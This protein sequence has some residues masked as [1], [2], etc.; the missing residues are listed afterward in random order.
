MPTGERKQGN[1]GVG[2]VEKRFIGCEIQKKKKKSGGF[3]I[4]F[5]K[6]GGV[7]WCT[8][9]QILVK[10]CLFQLKILTKCLK[11]AQS[12]RKI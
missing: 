3:G 9:C 12:A 8:F 5:P 1:F 11:C 4:N 7:N 10:I 6:K 2:F